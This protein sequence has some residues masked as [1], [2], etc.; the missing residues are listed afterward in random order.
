[1][2]T[3]L[4]GVSALLVA[5]AS[6]PAAPPE[7]L[8]SVWYRGSPA[9]Q[10]RLDDLAAIRALGFSGVTWPL[11]QTDRMAELRDMAATV[12]LSVIVRPLPRASG[13][14]GM[15]AID[16][17]VDLAVSGPL[18]G[19]IAARSW[20]AV[21]KGARVLSFDPGQ[22]EGTGL[23]M[24]NGQTP[25]W[26]A[27]A[28][29]IARQLS[30]NASLV[31]R[32]RPGPPVTIEAPAAAGL[33][34]VMLDG[35]GSWIIVA[36]NLGATRQKA[37]AALLSGIPYGLWVSWLDGTDLSMLSTPN[38]PRWTFEIDAGKA[39]VYITGKKQR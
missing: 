22:T 33:E 10:P 31:D 27:P 8:V 4:A 23:T 16:S 36:T 14:D 24:P 25:A 37:V 30:A 19:S 9:G 34:V 39:L 35:E 3:R 2:V 7:P 28:V 15:P 18:A 20:R 5:M 38:G 1:M 21:T 11:G 12:G 17:H 32:L 6:V 13:A 26:V 29:A